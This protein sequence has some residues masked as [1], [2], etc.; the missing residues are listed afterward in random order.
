MH[1]FSRLREHKEEKN[2]ER[3]RKK[4][5]RDTHHSDH[6]NSTVGQESQYPRSFSL[7]PLLLLL[8]SPT[9][10]TSSPHSNKKSL[11]DRKRE[12]CCTLSMLM[13]FMLK[14][15]HHSGP[16]RLFSPRRRSGGAQFADSEDKRCT[17]KKGE[18][19][20]ERVR[21]RRSAMECR[22]HTHTHACRRRVK[23]ATRLPSEDQLN[24]L[25]M[26]KREKIKKK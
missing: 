17:A 20:K 7:P 22:Q 16:S 5:T 23:R 2:R 3:K 13:A 10:M 21:G 8:R 19:E 9:R 6:A 15:H 18:I 1:V 14:R 11:S 4:R 26:G 25:G 24:T 12:S